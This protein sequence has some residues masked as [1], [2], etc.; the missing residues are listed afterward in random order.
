M[1]N[2]LRVVSLDNKTL[3][4]TYGSKWHIYKWK[5]GNLPV[6]ST[7]APW[8]QGISLVKAVLGKGLS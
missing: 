5:L 7:P 3:M 2:D 8:I 4:T 1:W 6:D